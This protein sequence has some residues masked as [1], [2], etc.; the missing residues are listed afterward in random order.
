MRRFGSER[1]VRLGHRAG[2]E[3]A[4]AEQAGEGDVAQADEA[5]AEEVTPGSLDSVEK[6]RAEWGHF[7][8]GLRGWVIP[9]S[10]VIRG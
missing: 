10:W 1:V 5:L 8:L 4:I 3:L 9:A 7:R 2:Q 6:L